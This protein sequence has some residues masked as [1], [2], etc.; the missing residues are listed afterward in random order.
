[1]NKMNDT[2]LRKAACFC[3]ASLAFACQGEHNA[4]SPRE[5]EAGWELLFDGK[6]LQGWRDYNGTALTAPW[7]VENG[8]LAASGQGDDGNGYIVT[9]K[10][11]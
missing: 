3:A 8:A 5:K 4:L 11:Y 2:F 10:E 1:M 7:T 9:E 6:T